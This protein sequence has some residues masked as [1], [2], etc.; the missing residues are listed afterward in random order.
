MDSALLNTAATAAGS[1]FLVFLGGWDVDRRTRR[2]EARRAA[3][4]DR[5]ALEAEADAFVTAV[6]A[7]RVQGNAHDHLWGGWRA[8]SVVVLHALA[9]GGAAYAAGHGRRTTS[10]GLMAGYGAASEVIG[11]WDRESAVSAVRLTVPLDRLGAALAPL[12]RRPEPL[13]GAA[14]EVFTAVV[15][16]YQDTVRSERALAAFHQALAALPAP[17][18]PRRRFLRRGVGRTTTEGTAPTEGQ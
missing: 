16:H 5:A 13:A 1:A 4:E 17:A 18:A 14:R 2:A 11:R 9:Q 7:V 8:R 10:A 12:L 15:D 6:L 3:A